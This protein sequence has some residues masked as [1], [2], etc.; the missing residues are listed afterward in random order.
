MDAVY[1]AIAAL[2]GS[3]LTFFSGFGLG[4]ILVPVFALFFPLD[5]AIAMTAIVHLLN[6][7][8]KFGLVGSNADWRLVITFGL[9]SMIASFFGAYLLARL[10]SESHQL[11]FVL[12]GHT[13]ITNIINL[14]VGLLMIVFAVVE[15]LP[16][17]RIV[18]PSKSILVVGG[19]VSGFFGG[20]SGNQGALRSIFLVKTTASKDTFVATGIVIACL[21]DISRLIIYSR[22][23]TWFATDLP[24]TPLVLGCLSAFTGAIIGK[25]LLKKTTLHLVQKIVAFAL[26]LF[27]S[28]IMLGVL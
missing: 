7:L 12:F 28:L 21:V 18:T 24:L 27:G 15:L 26:I 4:T 25:Q 3:A 11:N 23:L 16:G 22:F 8:F 19:L 13:F 6:N 20:L 9:P 14:T 17:I 5:I 2:V 1:I 10:G